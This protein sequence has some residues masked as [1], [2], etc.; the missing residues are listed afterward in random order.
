MP[1]MSSFHYNDRASTESLIR[2]SEI[3]DIDDRAAALYRPHFL[4]PRRSRWTKYVSARLLRRIIHLVLL[5]IVAV[6]AVVAVTFVFFP[7]YTHR[8]AHYQYL[9]GSIKRSQEPGRGNPRNEKVFIATNLYDRSGDLA[10]GRWGHSLLELVDLLG[11]DNTFL[12]IYENDAGEEADRALAELDAQ[13]HCN[14]SIVFEPHYDFSQ[15]ETVTLPDGSVRFRR[16]PYLADLRNQ[17]LAPLAEQ[18]KKGIRYDRILFMNDVYFDPVD[19]V[20]LLFST[21][22]GDDGVSNYR[23]ACAVDFGKVTRFYDTFAVRDAQGYRIGVPFYPW[24]V[25]AGEAASRKDVL[26]QKDAVRVRSCWGGIVAFDAKYFQVAE[27]EEEEEEDS[28]SSL[29]HKTPTDRRKQQQQTANTTSTEP[30]RF[31]AISDT[32]WE[33]SESCLIHADLQDPYTDI[34]EVVDTGIYLNPYIRVTYEYRAFTRLGFVRRFERLFAWPNWI[35]NAMSNHP[36]HNSRRT[37]IAGE[38]VEQRV[39]Q[40]DASY[41]EGGYWKDEL[42]VAS[43]GGFCAKRDLFVLIDNRQEGENGWEPIWTPRDPDSLDWIS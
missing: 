5:L 4:F 37:D 32:F 42:R 34:D 2:D 7:S 20:Q 43:A 15:A 19:I 12:S 39:W 14:K 36:Y 23:A 1:A 40:P 26:N 25:S 11:H 29:I 38:T 16:V 13:V 22:M 27:E 28:K 18:N 17:A 8:P 6:V 3:F 24:F 35:A 10:R 30:V 31:R 9:E 21:N 41:D 33:A